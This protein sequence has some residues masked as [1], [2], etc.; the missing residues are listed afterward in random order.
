ML[1]YDINMRIHVDVQMRLAVHFRSPFTTD[2][3]QNQEKFF[4][5]Q[6]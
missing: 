3:S 4:S 6:K 5:L 2:K 1:E